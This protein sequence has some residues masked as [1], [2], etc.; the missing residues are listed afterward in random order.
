LAL[1]VPCPEHAKQL[2]DGWM[3]LRVTDKGKKIIDYAMQFGNQM[4]IVTFMEAGIE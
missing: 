4:A 3:E 1:V 2:G